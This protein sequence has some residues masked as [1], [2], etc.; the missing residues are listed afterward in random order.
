MSWLERSLDNVISRPRST[1]IS[2][3]HSLSTLDQAEGSVV[4]L[5]MVIIINGLF[6]SMTNLKKIIKKM[7]WW[8]D[9]LFSSNVSSTTDN[10]RQTFQPPPSRFTN[11]HCKKA[12]VGLFYDFYKDLMAQYLLLLCGMI[13]RC[14]W[15]VQHVKCTITASLY[16]F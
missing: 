16:A 14:Q 9:D 2:S 1:T 15:L 11:P 8:V 13:Q 6:G 10:S 4:P 5:T 3:E 7:G 12:Q